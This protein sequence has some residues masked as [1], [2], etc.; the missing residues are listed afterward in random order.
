MNAAKSEGPFVPQRSRVGRLGPILL[1]STPPARL[2]ILRLGSR[3]GA[4]FEQD[5]E[6]VLEVIEQQES[7]YIVVLLSCASWEKLRAVSQR[8]PQQTEKGV[9]A[10]STP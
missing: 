5:T 6:Q 9:T 8:Y 3:D 7:G 10:Y 1:V 2:C 4:H